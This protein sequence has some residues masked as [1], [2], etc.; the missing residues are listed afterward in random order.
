MDFFLSR[1]VVPLHPQDPLGLWEDKVPQ[2]VDRQ[3]ISLVGRMIKSLG[4]IA[5]IRRVK[6]KELFPMEGISWILGDCFCGH[7]F[8]LLLGKIII[9]WD[10][11]F[12]FPFLVNFSLSRPGEKTS[13]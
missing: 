11:H 4:P 13:P 5:D 9:E 6:G 12:N 1:F 7:L 8:C 3:D 2:V 10:T